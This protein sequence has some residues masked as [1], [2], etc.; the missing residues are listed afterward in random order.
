ML[1]SLAARY[2][3]AVTVMNSI[4][5]A[6]EQNMR[7]DQKPA[8]PG[9]PTVE[10]RPRV[11]DMQAIN[12]YYF[13]NHITVNEVMIRMIERVVGHLNE[14]L[15]VGRDGDPDAVKAGNEWRDKAVVGGI[16]VNSDDDFMLPT[17]GEN[18]VTFRQVAQ[19]IQEMFRGDF[20]AHDNELVKVLEELVGFRLNGATA[21]DLM[22][23]FT[24][25]GGEAEQKLRDVISEGLA[26][27]KGSKASQR[28]EA[29]AEGPVSVKEAAQAALQKEA[30]DET[31]EETAAE[32]LER[33]AAARVQARLEQTVEAQ[34]KVAEAV[35]EA[36]ESGN[37]AKPGQPDVAVE[38]IQ[39]LAAQAEVHAPEET[40]ADAAEELRANLE[41]AEEGLPL[42]DDGSETEQSLAQTASE[43]E[44]PEALVRAYLETLLS[45]D[46]KAE[47]RR[48]WPEAA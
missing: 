9:M 16:D 11:K 26:G 37:P 42:V 8:M 47:L 45:D 29:A 28:L 15:S 34:D 18:G 22:K 10:T 3:P 35:K 46:E 32:D 48:R 43:P 24:E 20:L 36:A 27:Q 6:F 14:K 23:A 39:G 40:E 1:P 5:T 7:K 19:Q 13:G 25:P 30:Y 2:Q 17:P 21:A 31:D 41:N 12:D 33:V 44:A 38:I 4:V